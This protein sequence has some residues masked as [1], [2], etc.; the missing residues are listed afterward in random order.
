MGIVIGSAVIP[1]AFSITWAK[2]STAGAVGGA[3]SGLIGAVITWICV[4]KVSCGLGL[5]ALHQI[6]R[7]TVTV[8]WFL[9]R[10]RQR[11]VVCL[12]VIRPACC[13]RTSLSQHAKAC[14]GMCKS[15]G[16][17]R[18]CSLYWCARCSQAQSGVL[19]IDSLGGD[20][21]MLAGNV[22]AIGFSGL[23][24][25]VV[26][27]IKPQNYDW[28]LM[29]EIPMIE[30]DEN[31]FIGAVS[32]TVGA[33]LSCVGQCCRLCQVPARWNPWSDATRCSISHA[34]LCCRITITGG[35]LVID[36][37][38]TAVYRAALSPLLLAV[39]T[40]CLCVPAHMHSR[41]CKQGSE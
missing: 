18:P 21:P 27:L 23:V 2:C 25:V 1:I 34:A 5:T 24:C 37:A 38:V 3:I 14:T 11:G 10:Y 40:A 22:V 20:F 6:E 28:A 7:F 4:A 31:A 16:L 9:H 33:T 41:V 15:A 19:T 8:T 26:S 30:S 36:Q 35:S 39:C 17:T 12:A 29:K 32:H 13:N